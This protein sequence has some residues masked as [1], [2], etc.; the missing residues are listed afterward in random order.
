[1]NIY[2]LDITNTTANIAVA[3]GFGALD[4]SAGTG[5]QIIAS[6]SMFASYEDSEKGRSGESRAWSRMRTLARDAVDPFVRDAVRLAH[7]TI[8]EKRA[9]AQ[10]SKVDQAI[11]AGIGAR[12]RDQWADGIVRTLRIMSGSTEKVLAFVP[13]AQVRR[14]GNVQGAQDIPASVKR[15]SNALAT[16]AQAQIE[17]A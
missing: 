6:A 12:V 2:V 10:A 13:E 4:V 9:G 7:P 16:R 8:A 5:A 1:M 15:A 11:L 17:A 14:L 3:A